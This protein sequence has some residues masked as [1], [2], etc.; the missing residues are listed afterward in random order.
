MVTKTNLKRQNIGYKSRKDAK[1][2]PF[3][4]LLSLKHHI[5][6]PTELFLLNFSQY[7]APSNQCHVLSFEL[8]NPSLN[9]HVVHLYLLI[10]I[11]QLQIIRYHVVIGTIDF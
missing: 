10:E 4:L 3:A 5:H 6:K 7:G 2:L 8:T 9:V 1:G 11:E